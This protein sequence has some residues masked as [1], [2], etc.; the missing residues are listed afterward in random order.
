MMN[1]WGFGTVMAVIVALYATG[2]L[3]AQ[4]RLPALMPRLDRYL[5]VLEEREAIAKLR[6]AGER[7]DAEYAQ[8]QHAAPAAM[9]IPPDLEAVIAEESESWLRDEMRQTYRKLFVEY[10]DWNK[11]RRSVGIGAMES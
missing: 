7:A 1:A 10:G 11:V 3:L 9:V 8:R 4:V 5:A 6:L 2:R